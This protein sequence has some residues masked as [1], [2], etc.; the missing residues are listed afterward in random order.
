MKLMNHSST[1][2]TLRYIGITD[3]DIDDIYDS[4]SF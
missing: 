1:A 2:I 4:L 3:N